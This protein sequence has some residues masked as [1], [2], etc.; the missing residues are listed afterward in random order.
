MN[1]DFNGSFKRV[2]KCLFPFAP[3]T[4]TLLYLYRSSS[5]EMNFNSNITGSE[6]MH[7]IWHLGDER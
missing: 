1:S 2:Q 3:E 6:G 7:G 5:K 4:G